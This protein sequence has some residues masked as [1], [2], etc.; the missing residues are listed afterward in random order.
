MHGD[1]DYFR[2]HTDMSFDQKKSK[3]KTTT[4]RNNISVNVKGTGIEMRTFT[5]RSGAPADRLP[6]YCIIF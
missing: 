6:S 4:S 2:E 3:I 1:E 5:E